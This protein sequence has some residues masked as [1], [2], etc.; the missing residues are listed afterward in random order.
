MAI[1]QVLRMGHPTLLQVAQPVTEFNTAVLDA[2]IADMFDTM[3][4]Y[5]GVGLAAPQIG[6]SLRIIIFGFER[7]AR[8]PEAEPVPTTV[9]IN[10]D[11]EYPV[12]EQ[13]EG[14]E[15]CLS[16]PGMRGLVPRYTQIRY[17]GVDQAGTLID[18]SVNGFHARVVQHEVDHLDGILY[19][20]RVEDMTQFGF[21][22]E[23]GLRGGA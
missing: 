22:E 23:L 15:G 5:Q 1:R 8:Y 3:A 11:I 13:Q 16:V 6:V 14:W 19:P 18:R 4:E 10:P 7:N 2:L 12:A 20:Q 9:L 17:R 21:I